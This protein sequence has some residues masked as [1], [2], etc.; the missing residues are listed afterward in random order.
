MCLC[1]SHYIDLQYNPELQ[2]ISEADE[3]INDLIDQ[4]SIDRWPVAQ[5]NRPL[6]A[7]GAA[8]AVAVTLL[9]VGLVEIGLTAKAA[10][11]AITFTV[12]TFEFYT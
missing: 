11:S 6:R 5:G 1:R 8:M 2:P 4:I 9:E 3:S 10:Y 7:T 12:S